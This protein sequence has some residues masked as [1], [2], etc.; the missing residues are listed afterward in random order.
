[1]GTFQGIAFGNIEQLVDNAFFKKYSLGANIILRAFLYILATVFILNLFRFF[2][3]ERV[4]RI[5]FNK[6]SVMSEL[7]SWEYIFYLV[8]LYN[9]MM[10]L[11]VS[12]IT[13]VSRKFG[14]GKMMP[15]LLGKYRTPQ[16]EYRVFLFMDLQSST[17][18][19]EQLGHIKYSAMIRDCFFD[20]NLIASHHHGEVYQYVGDE[21]VLTWSTND[22]SK[23]STCMDFFFACEA[24]FKKQSSYYSRHYGFR[25]QFKV[26][27]H[28]GYVTAV[29]IGETKR[30][31]AYHGD[32][33]NT[34]ARIQ[35]LCNEY[36]QL[37]LI[38]EKLVEFV[39][40]SPYVLKSLGKIQ[41]KGKT[42]SSE[43]FSVVES[44]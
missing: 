33:L 44:H 24:Q 39:K 36:H 15:L 40:D 41:L 38:S 35:S 29:E 12:F 32:T 19:A 30:D 25:P 5:L 6:E 14:A 4:L 20:I 3:Y 26:G 17:A 9:F 42:S 1:M 43:I 10:S 22:L 11:V 31:I 28:V 21:V 18:I 16:E 13:L 23:P 34:A 8:L 27:A 7:D 37:F 2:I